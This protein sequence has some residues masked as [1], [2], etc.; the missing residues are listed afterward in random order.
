MGL[1]LVFP[2]CAQARGKPRGGEGQGAGRGVGGERRPSHTCAPQGWPASNPLP[3][4]AP[5]ASAPAASPGASPTLHV[6]RQGRPPC[7]PAA[8][9]ARE[10]TSSHR[11]PG[12]P[13]LVLRSPL[14]VRLHRALVATP[15]PDLAAATAPSSASGS[16]G[17]GGASAASPSGAGEAEAA[18]EDPRPPPRLARPQPPRVRPRC[19]HSGGPGPPGTAERRAGAEKRMRAGGSEVG[20]A[21][22]GGHR[23]R[24][25]GSPVPQAPADPR[26][27]VCHRLYGDFPRR[28]QRERPP[29]L[30]GPNSAAG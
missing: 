18:S 19:P 15:R 17:H 22:R 24:G 14:L 23:G 25:A 20:G 3:V 9:R 26:L 28:G 1:V 7:P 10:G 12:L 27:C 5:A 8:P 11:A 29:A 13:Y 6:G 16:R 2:P 30:L 21:G 4:A